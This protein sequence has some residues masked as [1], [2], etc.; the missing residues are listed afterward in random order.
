MSESETD[1]DGRSESAVEK[2]D[3][4][5]DF[6]DLY[7]QEEVAE[8]GLGC[9]SNLEG[10]DAVVGDTVNPNQVKTPTM[11]TDWSDPAVNKK[12]SE[13][14]SNKVDNPGCWSNYSYRPTFEQTTTKKGQK[15][16]S[17]KQYKACYLPTGCMLVPNSE[18][19][20]DEDNG[21][22][23]LICL[24]QDW[25]FH[26]QGWEL[27]N[28]PNPNGTDPIPPDGDVLFPPSCRGCLDASI[29]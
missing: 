10:K 21:Q 7:V 9:D 28:A 29:P 19:S 5:N 24:F 14:N 25:T 26:Y 27:E 2:D 12:W 22:D 6:N 3:D 1:S 20:D 8:E 13:P 17:K 16:L 23:N 4:A 18:D 11:P 15:K